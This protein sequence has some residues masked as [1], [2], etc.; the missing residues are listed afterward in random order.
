MTPS[1]PTRSSDSAK[2]FTN[3]VVAVSTD[4]ADLRYFQAAADGLGHLLQLHDSGVDGFID[5]TTNR[6]GD[7]CRQRY[8]E[9]L[10]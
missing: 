2:S 1:L 9:A 5:P 3:L 7:Y 10:L 6:G 8:C 4:G